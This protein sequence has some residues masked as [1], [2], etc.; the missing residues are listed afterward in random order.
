MAGHAGGPVWW[1]I[2]C[3]R[4]H[5][6]AEC[7]GRVVGAIKVYCKPPAFRS[8][9]RPAGGYCG[10]SIGSDRGSALSG[11]AVRIMRCEKGF[12]DM[13][14]GVVAPEGFSA[15][16]GRCW[17]WPSDDNDGFNGFSIEPV[18]RQRRRTSRTAETTNT[19]H[20]NHCRLCS[21]FINIHR[22]VDTSDL[23]KLP[24]PSYEIA[25]PI[26]I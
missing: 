1:D 3:V 8:P 16:L 24:D 4:D 9:G 6:L 2:V 7:S 11:P 5:W 17:Y 25:K 14:R 20:S 22:F 12:F 10:N 13:C 23:Y 21:L 19:Y 15:H 26:K 18:R